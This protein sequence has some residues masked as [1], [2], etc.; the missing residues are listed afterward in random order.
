M[1]APAFLGMIVIPL[2]ASPL[3]Y[4]AGRLSGAERTTR[5]AQVLA[6]GALAVTWI[7]FAVSSADLGTSPTTWTFGAISLR[8]DGLSLLLAAVALGLAL[9][10]A[11]F[12]GSYLRAEIGQEKFFAMLV[13]M[14]G[15]M[16]GLG[17][18]A[19]LF[20]LWIWFEAMAVC[21]YL[22]VA[23]HREQ[24]A[25]LEAGVKY[26]VQSAAGSVLV[27][28]GIALVFAETATLDLA[29]IQARATASPML[30]AAGALFVI[31]FGVKT[32]LAPLHTWLPDAHSMAPSGISAM[33]SGVVIEAGLV[34]MLR[35]VGALSGATA[36]WGP[37]L[38]ALGAVNMLVGNLMALRQT[39]VKRLLAFSSL[40][41]VGTMLL[42]IGVAALA[43]SALGGQGGLFHMVTHGMMKGLAFLAAGALLFTLHLQRG[44]HAPLTI[45]DLSGA[46]RRYPLAALALSVGVLGLGGIPPLAGFMSKWQIFVAGA[47]VGTA[48]LIGLVVF[49]ALNS[50]LSLAYYA[51]LVNAVYRRKASEAVVQGERMPRTMSVPLIVLACGV[52]AVGLWPSMMDW[53]TAPAGQAVAALFGG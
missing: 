31:G 36:I 39:Q 26:L 35:S 4:L 23:F 37:L 29:V 14:V 40:A 32:A 19:D 49:A 44:D 20:N 12:S 16:I 27:L 1:D 10:V 30:L 28:I 41:H 48:L 34:A 38:L 3:I 24:P 42:G 46:A 13:A 9:M 50:V 8:L 21:S 2:V 33:L 22:L 6:V 25:A 52:V 51:P 18:A 17:V 7:P 43:G 53:L 15:V 5:V 11:L 47:G 45:A